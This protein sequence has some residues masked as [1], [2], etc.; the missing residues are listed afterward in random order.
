[1]LAGSINSTVASVHADEGILRIRLRVHR[2][3]FNALV[4]NVNYKDTGNTNVAHMTT[5]PMYPLELESETLERENAWLYPT[6]R[7]LFF[8]TLHIN[9]GYVKHCFEK[10]VTPFATASSP[11]LRKSDFHLVTFYM[12]VT[13][14]LKLSEVLCKSYRY[15]SPSNPMNILFGL[16][17][18]LSCSARDPKRCRMVKQP[19][20]V[21]NKLAMGMAVV[22]HNAVDEA[23][24]W[25]QLDWNNIASAVVADAVQ[26][27]INYE[28]VRRG[29]TEL[30]R[31]CSGLTR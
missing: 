19:P 28:I 7:M 11:Y 17:T 24:L 16:F 31:P 29:S 10:L 13:G 2:F 20:V 8:N 22:Y 23:R 27:S 4:F 9:H 14:H 5:F 15:A 21:P 12:V 25:T 30:M 18:A 26:D 3:L 1:M 6:F